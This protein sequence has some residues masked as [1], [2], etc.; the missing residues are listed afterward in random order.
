[1]NNLKS[2]PPKADFITAIGIIRVSHLPRFFVNGGIWESN[3]PKAN[4]TPL[5]RYLPLSTCFRGRQG[6]GF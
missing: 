6:F 4:L 5:N 3:P 2:N 1:M